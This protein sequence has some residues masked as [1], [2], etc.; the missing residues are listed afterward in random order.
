MTYVDLVSRGTI[1]EYIVKALRKKIDLS[2]KTLG[3]EARQWLELT[4]RR[5][6]G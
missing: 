6:D 1:D 3:E 5:S 2:A 4:P